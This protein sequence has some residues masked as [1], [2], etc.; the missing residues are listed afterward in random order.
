[1]RAIGRPRFFSGRARQAHL[2]VSPF[3]VSRLCPEKRKAGRGTLLGRHGDI[4]EFSSRA[5]RRGTGIVSSLPIVAGPVQPKRGGCLDPQGSPGRQAPHLSVEF[6][7]FH[8]RR[9]PAFAVVADDLRDRIED[10]AF[11]GRAYQLEVFSVGPQ[12]GQH[13]LQGNMTVN[14]TEASSIPTRE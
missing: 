9:R 13:F 11:G 5:G 3:P 4:H 12:Q 14:S 8:R 1:M 6:P 7:Y 2:E 10:L